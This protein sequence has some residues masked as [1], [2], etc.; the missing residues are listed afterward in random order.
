MNTEHKAKL[1]E[2]HEQENKKFIIEIQNQEL[3]ENEG[4][5]LGVIIKT[6]YK[7]IEEALHKIELDLMTNLHYGFK[8]PIKIKIVEIK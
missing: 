6:E 4:E 7:S 1:K 5:V 8:N 2:R 3:A